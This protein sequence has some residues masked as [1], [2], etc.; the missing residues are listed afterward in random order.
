MLFAYYVI[1][2][3]S[4]ITMLAGVYMVMRLRK[5]AP[6]GVIG[7]VVNIILALIIFFALGYLMALYMPRLGLE[8]SLVLMSMVYLFGA[9]FVVVVLWLIQNLIQNVMKE[10]EI[11]K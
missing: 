9:V 5:V 6:G 2:I 1:I 10:L 3:C 11:K 4:I 8:T 7:R